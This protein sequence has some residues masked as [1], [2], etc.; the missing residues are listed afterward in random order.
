MHR[1]TTSRFYP[2]FLGLIALLLLLALLPPSTPAVRAA[3]T[4]SVSPSAITAT[5]TLGQ[6]ANHT[7][8]L[9][10]TSATPVTPLLY[11]AWPAAQTTPRRAPT[12]PLRVPLPPQR[13]RL[14]RKLLQEF[15]ESSDGRS[16]F[17]IFL[18]EQAD[19]SAAETISDWN[20]R[21]EY[22]YSTLTQWAETHQAD[23]RRELRR[24]GLPFQPFWIVNA[25]L[26]HGNLADA[27]A[28][29]AR[30]DVAMISANTT[31]TMPTVSP[32]PAAFA[33]CHQTDPICW[34]IR[35]IRA[36]QVW[37]QF[38]VDGAGVVIG[39]IDTGA[40]YTHPALQSSYRGNLGGGQ[41]KHDY[42]WYEPR[43]SLT[44]PADQNGHGTHTIGTMVGKGGG[45]T[46]KPHIGVA[47]GARWIAAQGCSSICSLAD[48]SAAAQWM[49]A[50]T[51]L[52]GSD[53]RPDLRPMII[54][55]SWSGPG[56]D[57]WYAGYTT[58][59]RAA[60]IFP[61]FAAGNLSGASC[62][63]I[64]SP[65]DYANVIAVGAT[66]LNDNIANFS[67]RGP[68]VDGRIKPDFSAP[69][70][71]VLSAWPN[72]GGY[73]TLNGT[74]MAAPH[75]AGTIA[76]M[77]SANPAL[78]GDYNATVDALRQSAHKISSNLCTSG[79]NVPNNLYGYGRIDAMEAV[80]KVRVDV[81]WLITPT[82]VATITGSGTTNINVTLD[83]SRVPGPGTYT[84]RL[85]VY[86]TLTEAPTTINV[87]MTVSPAPSQAQV[88]GRV[89]DAENNQP[90]A[91]NVRL[92][93][94]LG[95]STDST[96]VYTLTLAPG[97]YQLVASASSYVSAQRTLTVTALTHTLDFP[98]TAELP[99]ISVATSAI[100]NTIGFAEQRVFDINIKNEGLRPLTY[101]LDIPVDTFSVSRSDEP[102]GPTYSWVDLPANATKIP[103]TYNSYTD[104]IPL[105]ITFPFAS[106][107]FTETLVLSNGMI[108]FSQPLPS[109]QPLSTCLPD[110]TI[111]FYLIAPFRAELDP[112]RGGQIRYGTFA[113][114]GMFVLSYE[115]IP[116][117]EGPLSQT[118]TFQVLLFSDGRIIFQ[119]K[120]LADLPVKLSA[121]VQLSPQEVQQIGC[122]VSMPLQNNLAIELR[123]QVPSSDWLSIVSGSETGTLQPNQ[124]S[125]VRVRVK[126]TKNL[127]DFPFRGRIHI[128]NSDPRK[129]LVVVPVRIEHQKAP[130][131]LWLPVIRYFSM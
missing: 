85:Q 72:T 14:D 12:G 68:T 94:G 15:Q 62:S 3:T 49:L 118:Y 109:Q 5:V 23:L 89:Y 91:A 125:V 88:T 128:I 24:R 1:L 98:M 87:T 50:P 55:N 96:G 26:V 106:Y 126:W 107:Q 112:S 21:G 56:G 66:D 51:A 32:A 37:E 127:L 35:K 38:G 42:N 45:T 11:E 78:I 102:G 6:T 29:V 76:L 27:Q 99:Q 19:L 111:F 103:M 39:S 16:D 71:G 82:S 101:E 46:D 52:N 79:Q 93:N 8:T 47:P 7:I 77:W 2:S 4:I 80:S 28:M 122:G 34:N 95:V 121:G 113:D 131:Q 22:V 31:F 83:A 86:Q 124:Q 33:T 18:Q 74:S 69:G 75:V 17:L 58:A 130:H 123:P 84:A 104:T 67:Q 108:S 64:G 129:P 110:N 119:Y 54:N 36:E 117:H 100:S 13:E 114:R 48:L 53:P 70:E 25:V 44:V 57:D 81:P 60:G 115:N 43:Y 90:L 10:N 65:G 97:T 92:L 63:S 73:N 9:T 41:F 30:S 59:W 116:L 120:T 105:K 61:V 40:D 20:A